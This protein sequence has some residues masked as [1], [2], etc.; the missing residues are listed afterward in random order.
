MSIPQSEGQRMI[1][2]TDEH[3][4]RRHETAKSGGRLD[5]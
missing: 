2:F 1:G 4:L 3:R 5:T